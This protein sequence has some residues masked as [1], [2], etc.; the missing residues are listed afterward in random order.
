MV[1]PP[2]S[3][4]SQLRGLLLPKCFLVLRMTSIV[5]QEKLE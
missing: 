1:T 2:W 5:I 3:G 4:S